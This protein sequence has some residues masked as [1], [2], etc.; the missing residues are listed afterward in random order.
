MREELGLGLGFVRDLSVVDVVHHR[1]RSRRVTEK[2]A[3]VIGLQVKK[4]Q[5]SGRTNRRNVPAVRALGGAHVLH[6]AGDVHAGD[7][8]H[9]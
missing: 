3:W 4:P 8:G 7:G 6:G 2:S 5:L 9:C 1:R